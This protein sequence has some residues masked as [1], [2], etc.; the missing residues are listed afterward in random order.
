MEGGFFA[1][2]QENASAFRQYAVDLTQRGRRQRAPGDGVGKVIFLPRNFVGLRFDEEGI[3]EV[4]AVRPRMM[5][6]LQAGDQAY[7]HAL[8]HLQ[9]QIV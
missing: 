6:L 5:E 3:V 7:Q 8:G 4:A 2:L 1:T 9:G